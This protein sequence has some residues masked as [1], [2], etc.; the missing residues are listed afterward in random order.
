M[1]ILSRKRPTTRIVLP[2]STENDE[3]WVDVYNSANAEDV[4]C[5]QKDLDDKAKATMVGLARIISDWSFTDENLQKLEITPE[6]IGLLDVKDF[7]YLSEN[8]KAYSEVQISTQ[9]KSN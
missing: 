2:S 5:M 1:P 7:T 9:K 4:L 8:I 3:A 6:N